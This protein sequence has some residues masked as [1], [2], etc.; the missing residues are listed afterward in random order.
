MKRLILMLSLLTPALPL[1]AQPQR[2]TLDDCRDMAVRTNKALDQAR[3]EIE[4]AGYDRKIALANYFPKISA[5]GTYQYN[6]RD[7]ALISDSQSAMLRGAGDLMQ[8]QLDGA[9]SAM[10][11]QISGA[12]T[13]AM[14]GSMT[15]LMTA[16]QTNP[17]LALDYM[18]SPMWQT[19]LGMLQQTDPSALV[20]LQAPD[21][22]GPVNA[23]GADIDQALHPDMHNI[24][25]GAVSVEQPLF[26]GGKII[27]SNKMATLS[28][29]LAKAGYDQEYAQ[30]LVDVE[31]AYWQIVSIAGKKR[32]AD[33]YVDL[34]QTLQ[35]NVKAS[36]ATGVLTESDALQI[37]VKV[38]EAEML[39]TKAANGLTLSKM[40]LCQRIGL[41]LESEIVLADE[42]LDI[43][44]L[45]Q[46][47]PGKSLEDI[48]ADRPETRRL[49]LAA[50][51]Y[52]AKAKV[53]RGD[54]LPTVA[55][56]ANYLISNPNAFNG[57][58]NTWNGG[59]F[60][61]GV[62]VNIPLFH[63]LENTNRY[64][65]AKAEASLYRSQLENAKEMIELQVTRER[66]TYDEA[67]EKLS[68]AESNLESAEEN[69]RAAT[70][71]FEA[72]VITT[73]TVLGAQT[74]WLSA[75]IDC[76]DAG[77]EL[78]IAAAALRQ[79]EG[80]MNHENK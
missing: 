30:V 39:R 4:M 34:L 80:N 12:L 68:M 75:N 42:D 5:T 61:A 56:T 47:G 59:M 52:D 41:P 21:I 9:V 70:V 10:N 62:V 28:E 2:L 11:Q 27:Y 23:I 26:A 44:P 60:C 73:D 13:Q 22:A 18:T 33:A 25:L 43:V 66:K 79:A 24:W 45:P 54:G 67:L 63:G 40:L 8:A 49:E 50:Q 71:G 31:Q 55:L 38:N 15:E 76:L 37:K 3:T 53:T 29:D 48:W 36:V 17:L 72:G 1:L 58:Q 78:Q 32:L 69:L 20:Q 19:V 16:I 57:I 35:N 74:A 14:T 65:K 51:I 46:C 6:N 77:T 7:I 64:R